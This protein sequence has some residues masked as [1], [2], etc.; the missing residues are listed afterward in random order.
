MQAR[1]PAEALYQYADRLQPIRGLVV[2]YPDHGPT[3]TRFVLKSHDAPGYL[4]IF[5]DHT[6]DSEYLR[7]D[8]GDELILRARPRPPRNFG[9][10]DYRDYLKRRD[11]W[12]VV[13]VYRASEIEIVARR[14]GAV[15]VQLGYELRRALFARLERSL[16]PDH[17][18]LLKG[19]LFG[20]RES[21]P[22]EIESSFRDA[23]VMHVLAVSGANLGMILSLLALL[24][25][26]W[27]FNFSRLYVIALPVV[28]FYLL[29]VGFEISL[30]RATLIFL[31]LTLGFVCAECGWLLKRW[32][33]L[34]QGLAAAGLAILLCDPEALFEA[35]LQLSFTATLGILLAVLYLWPW[36]SERL[37][38]KARGDE[39]W[40]IRTARWLL[41]FLLVS[42]A[43]QLFVAPIIALQFQRLYLWGAILGNLMIVPLVTIALWGGIALLGISALPI[44]FLTDLA[45]LAEGALLQLLIDLSSFFAQLPGAVWAW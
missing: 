23:G 1:F 40:W 17:S 13:R 42:L 24:L 21:L 34:L 27:G 5:Y 22:K 31:F 6:R 29:V 20:K 16:A 45:A 35:S 38:L 39:L 43:A 25:S 28:S 12:G 4:Q 18:A 14:R 8:Y 11:I 32:A 41:F 15:L 33:D 19:L 3:R 37:K 30:V 7:I 10:F 36:L 26:A 2:N 9:N 44:A